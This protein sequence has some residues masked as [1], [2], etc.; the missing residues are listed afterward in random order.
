M[1][2]NNT[3]VESI[4]NL[5]A[6]TDRLRAELEEL[7]TR[8]DTFNDTRRAMLFLLEDL[9]E[10]EKKYR[11][12][13]Q[14]IPGVVYR[15]LIDSNWSMLYLNDEIESITGYPV[16]DFINNQVRSFASIIHP[17][18]R[19]MV[20]EQI[21]EAVNEAIPYFIDYRICNSK[22]DIKWVHVRGQAGFENKTEQIW[23]DGTIVDITDRRLAEI[24]LNESNMRLQ[25]AT[26]AVRD[27]LVVIKSDDG[28]I[29][30]WNPAATTIF[31]YSV[32][33]AIG[34]KLHDLIAPERF[35]EA[36]NNSMRTFS[37]SGEG[38][39]V[40]KLVE[41]TGLRK[42]G[43]EFPIEL[44]VSAMQL[45][46]G[47]YGVGIAR[48][49][50]ARKMAEK[51]KQRA[52]IQL[53]GA[54]LGTIK[55]V[56]LT[57]EKRDPYTSGHQERVSK[58]ATSIAKLLGLTDAQI[59]GIRLGAAIHDIGKIAIPAEI[60]NRPGKLT[61]LELG[62]IQSH[63][64]IGFDII[65]GVDFPWP[66]AEMIHQHHERMDGSGYPQGLKG[67][68]I[69]LEAR[70]IAVADVVEAINSHRPYRPA[71]GIDE[72]LDVVRKGR[73]VLFDSR[74]A[75]ACLTLFQGTPAFTF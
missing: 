62:L 46:D 10:N 27:A 4:G 23:L 16:S 51:D 11:T 3:E 33:E 34:I 47:F 22:G 60:L 2:T 19:E 55:S 70:I 58:L 1:T 67:E 43:S 41:L 21:M 18:D 35:H 37:A 52:A 28:S 45:S 63:P 59:E 29:V 9:E 53:K 8:L 25:S 14:N 24:A 69:I 26:N 5:R 17:D 57:I 44:S 71:Y 74:V 56:S 61:E 66:V 38:N 20:R 65:K 7:H 42:D 72:A 68:E 31:G 30:S 75:D 32:E 15:C 49:I 40:G 50:S 13:V 54:L 36:I 39:F 12:L 48:D 64:E 73:G 6:E